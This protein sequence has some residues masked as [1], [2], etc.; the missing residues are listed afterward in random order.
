VHIPV[1]IY[2]SRIVRKSNKYNM[3]IVVKL[4]SVFY[5]LS[6]NNLK[7]QSYALLETEPN[8][9]LTPSS[10]TD[11]FSS[12]TLTCQILPQTMHTVKRLSD[13][14]KSG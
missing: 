10:Y 8:I 12:C 6:A 7:R 2:V 4:I 14:E 5:S 9:T 1:N 3:L 11:L 13:R